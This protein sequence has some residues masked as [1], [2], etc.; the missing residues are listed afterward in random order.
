MLNHC[1]VNLNSTDDYT[2]F[3]QKELVSI[4]HA[5]NEFVIKGHLKLCHGK[6]KCTNIDKTSLITYQPQDDKKVLWQKIYDALKPL[7]SYEYCWTELKFLKLIDVVFKGLG[8][9]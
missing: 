5:F 4:I 2:C 3:T 9:V 8:Y 7:C 6:N 1:A